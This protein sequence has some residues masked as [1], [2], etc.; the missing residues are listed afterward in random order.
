MDL[1]F[2]ETVAFHAD[3]NELVDQLIPKVRASPAIDWTWTAI[4]GSCN[5]AIR[6]GGI[7]LWKTAVFQMRE[8][9][10]GE[11][12]H[13]KPLTFRRHEDTDG[14]REMSA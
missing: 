2:R 11:A 6:S 7:E 1:I 10:I 8:S 14:H 4:K 3:D 12:T 5:Q 9:G 13:S